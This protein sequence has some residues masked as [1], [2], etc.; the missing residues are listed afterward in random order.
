MYDSH[1]K[2]GTLVDKMDGGI[3]IHLM[4]GADRR[5][6]AMNKL[7]GSCDLNREVQRI[8]RWGGILNITLGR[9]LAGTASDKELKVKTLL[10]HIDP[11]EEIII[12]YNRNNVVNTVHAFMVQ[13]SLRDVLNKNV[14][15]IKYDSKSLGSVIP[16]LNETVLH[17]KC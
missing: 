2:L 15:H 7:K 10:T 9:P 17:I 4:C 1:I 6:V 5:V 16:H 3:D 13:S 8:F 11:N 14:K 12:S